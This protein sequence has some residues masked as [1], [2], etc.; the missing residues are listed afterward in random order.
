MYL[1]IVN[2]VLMQDLVAKLLIHMSQG[3]GA[4][5]RNA[6]SLFLFEINLK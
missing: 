1:C 5:E 2:F 4:I 3:T 6:P